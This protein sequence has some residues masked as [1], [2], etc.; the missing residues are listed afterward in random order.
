MHH[1]ISSTQK[2]RQKRAFFRFLVS[3]L[4]LLAIFILLYLINNLQVH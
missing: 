4:G 2:A 3:A 1:V